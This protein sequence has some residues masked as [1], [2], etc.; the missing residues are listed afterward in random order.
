[1]FTVKNFGAV[2][3]KYVIF[4]QNSGLKTRGKFVKTVF[5]DVGKSKKENWTWDAETKIKAQGF[6]CCNKVVWTS[7]SIFFNF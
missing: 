6:V 4:D 5:Q 2:Y 1:M 3:V 7:F